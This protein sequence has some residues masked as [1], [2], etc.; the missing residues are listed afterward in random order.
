MLQIKNKFLNKYKT[1]RYKLNN[2][3]KITLFSYIIAIVL[4]SSCKKAQENINI[5][6]LQENPTSILGQET[7]AD[8]RI[9][10]NGNARAEDK[11][12]MDQISCIGIF[13]NG[14]ERVMVNSVKL[15]DYV[16]PSVLTDKMYEGHLFTVSPEY[17]NF[18]NKYGK[19]IKLEVV[20]GD[21]FPSFSK[22]IRLSEKMS[23]INLPTTI[24]KSNGVSINFTPENVSENCTNVV[25]ISYDPNM[26]K[27]YDSSLPSEGASMLMYDTEIG[28]NHIDF[29][30]EDL[31]KMPL[32][33]HVTIT[34][35]RVA[36]EYIYVGDKRIEVLNLTSQFSSSTKIV[37]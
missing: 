6:A 15:G 21:N 18:V 23:I 10:I 19:T 22:D 11:D 17:Q 36:K 29:T 4:L 24:S 31:A 28:L 3:N 7:D 5:Q 14:T 25:I 27:L 30:A 2:M 16:F 9:V 12:F 1:N 13:K 37:Q 32:N 8:A 34:L 33:G 20:G 26:S 35:V